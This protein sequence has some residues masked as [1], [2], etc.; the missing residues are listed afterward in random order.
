MWRNSQER[1]CY[2]G[3][4]RELHGWKFGLRS[5]FATVK[6][7]TE[8]CGHF[9]IGG[10]MKY[11]EKLTSTLTIKVVM[12]CDQKLLSFFK[13]TQKREETDD[14]QCLGEIK[15]DKNRTYYPFLK[16]CAQ[17]G[18]EYLLWFDS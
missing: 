14:G 7:D 13:M 12:D 5:S 15:F 6:D 17:E 11:C 9:R 10:P 1:M 2:L 18:I 3:I 8:H 16:C 4:C